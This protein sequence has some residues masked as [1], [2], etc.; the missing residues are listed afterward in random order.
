MLIPGAGIDPRIYRATIAALGELGQRALAPVLPLD[1][2]DAAPSDHAAAVLAA[3]PE[4]GGDLVVVAQSLG[5]F[6]GPLVAERAEAAGL[7]LL[8]PMIPAPGETAGEW[9]ANTG[10][11]AAIAGLRERFG[12]MSEWGREALAE[13]FLHDVDEATVRANARYEGAPGRG[14]FAEPW[15]LDLFPRISPE[16]ATSSSPPQGPRTAGPPCLGTGDSGH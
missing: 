3:L 15:P 7:V 14:M 12:P 10:H 9:W 6:A 16:K 2:E 11:E 13:V 5:A 1:D 8:A 4:D